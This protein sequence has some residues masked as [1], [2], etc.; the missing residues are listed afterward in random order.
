M[1][2]KPQCGIPGFLLLTPTSSHDSYLLTYLFSEHLL[3]S[4]TSAGNPG[5]MFMPEITYHSQKQLRG[6]RICCSIHS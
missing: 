5:F 6:E 4:V 2:T 1:E 3:A